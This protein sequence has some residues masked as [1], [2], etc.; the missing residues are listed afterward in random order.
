MMRLGV[1]LVAVAVIAVLWVANCSGP[2]PSVGDVRLIPPSSDGAPY[3]VEAT[4]RR[5]RP[6][7]RRGRGDRSPARRSGRP[8]NI[9][10]QPQARPRGARNDAPRRRR[11]GATRRVHPRRRDR[12]PAPLTRPRPPAPVSEICALCLKMREGADT[13]VANVVHRTR[14]ARVSLT[15]TCGDIMRAHERHDRCRPGRPAWPR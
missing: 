10:N 7:P 1:G 12:L 11:A 4:N 6:R 9:K 2:Q 13:S 8:E 14:N 5:H 15:L 3:R